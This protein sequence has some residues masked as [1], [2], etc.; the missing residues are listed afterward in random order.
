V[1]AVEKAINNP[2]LDVD[3]SGAKGALINVVGG[4]SMTLEEARLVVE[5]VSTKLDS[6]AKIIW[7]AQI[8]ADMHDTVRAMLVITG[9]QSPQ[10]FG[11]DKT[12]SVAKQKEMESEL[13]IKFLRE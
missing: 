9:V 6:D 5:T 11:R 12:L 1:E 7:G 3:I 8:S 10:I 2:L 4:P 13:G